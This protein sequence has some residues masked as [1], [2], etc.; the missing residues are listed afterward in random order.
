MNKEVIY[1][2]ELSPLELYEALRTSFDDL[3][4][5]EGKP[6]RQEEII[7]PEKAPRFPLFLRHAALQK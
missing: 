5:E 6:V 7:Q 3:Y 2:S 4:V 1:A